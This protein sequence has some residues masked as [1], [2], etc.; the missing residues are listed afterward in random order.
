MLLVVFVSVPLLFLS[1]SSWPQSNIPGFWQG[2]SW[3]FPSTFGVR[4]YVRINTMGGT[5]TDVLT[6]YRILWIQVAAYFILA[7]LVYRHQIR[8]A[9]FHALERL[10]FLMKRKAQRKKQA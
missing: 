5:L 4:A 7:C 9:R 1:G 3:L 8:Q 2:I 6:E 10:D